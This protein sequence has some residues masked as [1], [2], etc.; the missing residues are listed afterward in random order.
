MRVLSRFKASTIRRWL[1]AVGAA[2]VDPAGVLVCAVLLWLG[3][4]GLCIA[5]LLVSREDAY[6]QAIQVGRNL[7]LVLERDIVR[8]VEL[9]DL[10]LRA[11]AEGA[12]NPSVMSLPKEL[13]NQ[14]L[15]ERPTTAR[16]L[17]PITVYGPD[18]T[19]QACSI[20]TSIRRTHRPDVRWFITQAEK[21]DAG[22][23]VSAPYASRTAGGKIVLALGRQI[24]SPDGKFAGVVVGRLSIDYFRELLDGLSVG[25][26][27]GMAVIETNGILLT[28]L[29]YNRNDVGKDF[30]HSPVF[31][32]FMKDGAGSFVGTA[33]ID[34]VRRLYVYRHIH[35][36]PFVVGVAPA[37]SEVYAGWRWRASWV[38]L[39]MALFTVALAAGAWSLMSEL[40]RRQVAR[41]QLQRMARR[42]ALTG[43]ENRGTFDE[44][45]RREFL[46][47]KRNGTPLSLL[48]ID[49]DNFKAYNDHYGHQAGDYV[50]KRVAS[51]IASRVFRPGDHVA[52]YG[53][54]EFV[55][56]LPETDAGSAVLIAEEIRLA[57]YELDIK[58]VKS[59][60]GRVTIS[61]GAAS[62]GEPDTVDEAAL[63][64]AA[65]MATYDAKSTGRNRVCWHTASNGLNADEH[66]KNT[67]PGD[68][69]HP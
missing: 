30:S 16:Y 7:T 29:P 23:Y 36:L 26:Q 49:I 8:S 45:S 62:S 27:G 12:A 33:T 22:L 41:A 28:R 44:V 15:F 60:Y 18:G 59:Q 64:K 69:A 52:R 25:K 14:V 32:R 1:L 10:S 66:I 19:V 35:G 40:R 63:I 5:M 58:H 11:V 48:F 34:G 46:R 31:V 56:V 67:E 57:I 54:E 43:L 53:G 61:I 21:T 37:L 50:I 6:H 51:R 4:A 20:E 3:T 24:T 65:D 55:V 47:A 17:G 13:R 42:D 9:Y 38:A 39:L 2:A 68:Q